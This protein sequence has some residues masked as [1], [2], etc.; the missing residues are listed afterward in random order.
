MRLEQK[1]N[2]VTPYKT[3]QVGDLAARWSRFDLLL[4]ALALLPAERVVPVPRSALARNPH[5]TWRLLTDLLD[6][7]PV[8]LPSVCPTLATHHKRAG[9][10]QRHEETCIARQS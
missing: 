3:A 7:S 5:E 4:D 1:T 10:I 9:L 2:A 6:L 8:P